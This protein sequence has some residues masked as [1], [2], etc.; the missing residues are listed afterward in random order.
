MEV[1]NERCA[2]IDIHEKTVQVCCITPDALGQRHK[3]LQ[4]FATKTQD[5]LILSAWLKPAG[6]THMAM[7][8]PGC[9]RNLFT[10][11]WK[12]S[13]TFLSSTHTISKRFQDARPM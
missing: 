10:T 5:L 1:V 4:R 9:I 8:V 11:F 7:E 6:C 12:G 13:L 2:G 3:S